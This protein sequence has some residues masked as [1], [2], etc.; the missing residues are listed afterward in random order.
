MSPDTLGKLSSF[1]KNSRFGFISRDKESVPMYQE[2]FKSE[3]GRKLNLTSCTLADTEKV[4]AQLD[5]ADV[6]LATP[7]VFEDVKKLAAGRIPVF[8]TF[9]RVDPQSLN[10]VK[11]GI[12]RKLSLF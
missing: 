7:P 2:L 11:N 3:F 8:C 10:I 4:Q 9:D 1:D 6:L 5:S 12:L